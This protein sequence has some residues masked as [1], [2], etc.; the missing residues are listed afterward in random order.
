MFKSIKRH[1][2]I[3]PLN[4]DD[5]LWIYLP[6]VFVALFA[7]LLAFVIVADPLF[8]LYPFGPQKTETV[9]V[10][11]LYVDAHGKFSSYM[12]GTDK[13]VFEMDNSLILGIYNIDELY[14]KLQDGKTY[15]VT[16]KG[17]KLT[18]WYCNEYPHITTVKELN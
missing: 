3:W 17:N 2:T 12:V 11:R 4:L 15:E 10:E 9:T 6:F 7:G 1:F 8:G 14:A 18:T 5:I 13:G 16:L